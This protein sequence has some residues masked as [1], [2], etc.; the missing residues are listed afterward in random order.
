MS[1]QS[2]V[3]RQYNSFS[4]DRYL[5]AVRQQS[6]VP[7]TDILGLHC[8]YP[9]YGYPS[10]HDALANSNVH[11]SNRLQNHTPRNPFRHLKQQRKH[12]SI[13]PSHQAIQ[14]AQRQTPRQTTQQTRRPH[15]RHVPDGFCAENLFKFFFFK[16]SPSPSFRL[17][18]SCSMSRTC[19]FCPVRCDCSVH[20]SHMTRVSAVSACVCFH[21][22]HP[23][24]SVM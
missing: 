24:A 4:I 9:T 11:D 3:R 16:I 5:T 13:R 22:T 12:H 7:S 18:F 15:S 20:I 17:L 8:M 14:H 19:G 2:I 10:L 23:P 21:A 1:R 6:R